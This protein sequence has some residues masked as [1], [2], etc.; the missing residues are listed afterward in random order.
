MIRG[1]EYIVF[2]QTNCVNNRRC[3]MAKR[4]EVENFLCRFYREINEQGVVYTKSEGKGIQ[5]LVDLQLTVE[6][7]DK[8]V[9]GL[10][11]ENYCAGPLC[12]LV[13]YIAEAWV[14]GV[15]IM[16]EDLYIRISLSPRSEAVRILFDIATAPL[17]YP[18]QQLKGVNPKSIPK[19]IMV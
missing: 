19:Q 6:E 15:S 13:P 4:I 9:E 11:V 12:I 3:R 16:R 1:K 17:V 8:T 14:F 7:R 2:K 5:T 18:Y 10:V